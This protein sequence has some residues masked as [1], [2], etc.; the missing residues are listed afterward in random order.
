MGPVRTQRCPVRLHALRSHASAAP[1][2]DGKRIQRP[3]WGDFR[4]PDLKPLVEGCRKLT[5]VTTAGQRD[6]C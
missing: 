3:S 5:T 4:P 6:C 1:A 2:C